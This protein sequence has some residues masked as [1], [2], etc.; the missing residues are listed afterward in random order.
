[1][2]KILVSSSKDNTLKYWDWKTGKR[3]GTQIFLKNN[4]S[5]IYTPDGQFDYSDKK[6]SEYVSYLADGL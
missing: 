4:T 1:M 3:S 2:G 6:A 5:L